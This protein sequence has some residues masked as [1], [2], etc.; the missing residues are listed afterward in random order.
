MATTL[1]KPGCITGVGTVI[2]FT[3]ATA[4]ASVSG[5]EVSAE[6][7]ERTR[8]GFNINVLSM[9]RGAY[10]RK[11]ANDFLEHGPIGLRYWFDPIVDLLPMDKEDFT[12]D[13]DFAGGPPATGT[14]N[15]KAS[16]TGTGWFSRH[17]I[18]T[19][20]ES[21]PVEETADFQFDG[22]TGPTFTKQTNNP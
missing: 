20:A 6:A 11:C 5:L 17:A 9:P 13:I 2:T 16:L 8:E 19:L 3:H 18:G 12:I 14:V 21:E 15:V 1:K 22:F 7:W 10:A 4:A